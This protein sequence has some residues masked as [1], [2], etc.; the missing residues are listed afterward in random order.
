MGEDHAMNEDDLGA[1]L[2]D[3]DLSTGFSKHDGELRLRDYFRYGRKV[4][5][6]RNGHQCTWCEKRIEDAACP[7]NVVI[8]EPLLGDD[9][10]SMERDFCC[11]ECAA[12]W[13]AGQAGRGP[14]YKDP[15]PPGGPPGEP[16]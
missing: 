6:L 2:P 4:T 10:E 1:D 5:V 11:W 3:R 8:F 13:F 7:L 12:D 15:I 9:G 16:Q 14:P